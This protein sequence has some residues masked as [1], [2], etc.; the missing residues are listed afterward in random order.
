M[1]HKVELT[2]H[3]LKFHQY[4]YLPWF[5]WV[6]CA[7]SLTGLQKLVWT[8]FCILFDSKDMQNVWL[9]RNLNGLQYH[10]NT[11]FTDIRNRWRLSMCY[12]LLFRKHSIYVTLQ[13]IK[14][15]ISRNC[16]MLGSR[17]KMTRCCIQKNL[18]M[19]WLTWSGHVS[20]A[21]GDRI[22]PLPGQVL[23]HILH[24]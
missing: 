3:K 17:I 21:H 6:Q 9:N 1:K 11:T 16:K 24:W 8:K 22:P 13:T 2:F 18:K 7:G 12:S 5:V 4:A 15:K 19:L 14:T 23:P 20:E 10:M